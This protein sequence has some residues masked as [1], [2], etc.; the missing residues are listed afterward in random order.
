M[1]VLLVRSLEDS[2][3]SHRSGVQG[4]VGHRLHLVGEALDERAEVDAALGLVAAAGVDADRAGGD[5]VVAD[6]EDVRQLLELAAAD[7][8]AELLA[9]PDDV[10]APAGRPD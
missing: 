4:G 5:V 3:G 9:R 8:L 2:L 6:H 7:A 10:D 1:T